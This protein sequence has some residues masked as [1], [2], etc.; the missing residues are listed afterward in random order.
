MYEVTIIMLC[1]EVRYELV[2]LGR[3]AGRY[4]AVQSVIVTE[5]ERALLITI[6]TEYAKKRIVLFEAKGYHPSTIGKLLESEGIH[7]R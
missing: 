3:A 2:P 7:V 5:L 6:L 1:R 4:V